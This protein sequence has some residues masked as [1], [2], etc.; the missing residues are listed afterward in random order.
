M[1]RSLVLL[2][3]CQCTAVQAVRMVKKAKKSDKSGASESMGQD[4]SDQGLADNVS[5]AEQGAAWSINPSAIT[6]AWKNCHHCDMRELQTVMYY[7]IAKMDRKKAIGAQ[8]V[9]FVKMGLSIT[10]TMVN[11]LLG[12]AFSV[13]AGLLGMGGADPKEEMIKKILEKVDK[14]IHKALSSFVHGWNQAHMASIVN[15]IQYATTSSDWSSISHQFSVP[16]VFNM[17]CYTKKEEDCEHFRTKFGAGEALV[18]EI[19]YTHL[20]INA[21]LEMLRA[22]DATGL[23]MEE[24]AKDSTNRFCDDLEI[25]LSRA[26]AMEPKIRE[27]SE[28]LYGHLK[29]WEKYRMKDEKFHL[30]TAVLSRARP[31]HKC[32]RVGSKVTLKQGYDEVLQ[33]E[34]AGDNCKESETYCTKDESSM[35]ASLTSCRNTWIA[36]AREEIDFMW[37]E[38]NAIK[39]VVASF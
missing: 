32:G 17:S 38:I 30:G 34:F 24:C 8:I 11:P 6:Q 10:L 26:A 18:L 19:E 16:Q 14:M 25:Y 29:S 23:T 31:S 2:V 28:L 27:A 20:M 35:K 3:A 12:L 22:A 7:N 33:G 5:L 4:E 1:L 39:A 36:S 13:F 15:N 21:W 9:G 37:E